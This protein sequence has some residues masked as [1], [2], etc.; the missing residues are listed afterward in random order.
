MNFASFKDLSR[1]NQSLFNLPFILS[2][3][4]LPVAEGYPLFAI[5]GFKWFWI[6]SAFFAARISGMAFNQ[7]IDHR[8]D[9]R[10]PRT[11]NRAIPKGRVLPKE[12]LLVACISLLLFFGICWQINH[13]CFLFSFFAAFLICIYSYMKRIHA[14]CHF[15]LGMI[16]LLGPVMA[17]SAISGRFS[18]S[19]LWLGLTA[20]LSNSG[21]DILYAI[22]DYEFDKAN[23]LHSIPVRL[24]ITRTLQLAAILHLLALVSMIM[25]GVIA[26]FP[27]FYYLSV[28]I[29][30]VV[31]YQF[32]ATVHKQYR[33]T[34]SV[35]GIESAFFFAQVG[36]AFVA[37][38]FILSSALWVVMS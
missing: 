9:A 4:L 1:L 18:L 20:L 14:S 38:L 15:V 10:N 2:G 32:H 11:K 12:A 37:F 31:F 36:V 17:A 25:L 5:G 24:G 8:I 28:G 21:S 27:F 30:L 19:S 33:K 26:N 29:L 34:G 35:G 3:A 22:Q 23:S 16:F 13:I 6:I 7:L